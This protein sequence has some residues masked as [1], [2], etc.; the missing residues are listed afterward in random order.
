MVSKPMKNDCYCFGRVTI[1]NMHQYINKTVMEL[2]AYESRGDGGI[3]SKAGGNNATD[4]D[5]NVIEATLA[6]IEPIPQLGLA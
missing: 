5:L 3:S 4:D 1:I 2:H 6:S